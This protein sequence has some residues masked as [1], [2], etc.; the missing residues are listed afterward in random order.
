MCKG[1]L[2]KS[3]LN[4]PYFEFSFFNSLDFFKH[5]ASSSQNIKIFL[6][7]FIF[8][9]G[10]LSNLVTYSYGWS[11]ICLHDEFEKKTSPTIKFNYYKSLFESSFNKSNS[12]EAWYF[13]LMSI[14]WN[15][16]YF[17]FNLSSTI[18]ML[19]LSKLQPWK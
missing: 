13:L 12:I 5:V 18:T 6:N 4:L 9:F 17:I 3:G 10:L 19:L 1:Y 16:G 7:F 2:W 14:W 8:I 15:H 11:L